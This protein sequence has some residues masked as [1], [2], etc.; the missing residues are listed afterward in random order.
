MPVN[1]GKAQVSAD[2][3]EIG[4]DLRLVLSKARDARARYFDNGISAEVNALAADDDPVPETAFDKAL[5]INTVTLLEQFINFMDGG[6]VAETAY[7]ITANQAA[8]LHVE[9]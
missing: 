4:N 7:R 1:N 3:A 9:A 2:L 8:A 5:M 6:A